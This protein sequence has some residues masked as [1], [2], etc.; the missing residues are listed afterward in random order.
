MVNVVFL[1][2]CAPTGKLKNEYVFLQFLNLHNTTLLFFYKISPKW[3]HSIDWLKLNIF[4]QLQSLIKKI[5][6][7]FEVLV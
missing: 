6:N 3:V 1:M 4:T 2:N 7:N 5:A